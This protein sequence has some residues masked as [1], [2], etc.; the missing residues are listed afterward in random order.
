M[1]DYCWGSDHSCDILMGRCLNV[2]CRFASLVLGKLVSSAFYAS[3]FIFAAFHHHLAI[4]AYRTN[5]R[6][7]SLISLLIPPAD[8]KSF[9]RF[10]NDLARFVRSPSGQ[11]LGFVKSRNLYYTSTNQPLLAE[12]RLRARL[13][14]SRRANP[15]LGLRFS[16]PETLHILLVRP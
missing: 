8:F 7:T 3:I 9:L 12:E 5:L 10:L 14:F 13:I 6:F 1:P 16:T 15:T 2:S 4:S 11:V